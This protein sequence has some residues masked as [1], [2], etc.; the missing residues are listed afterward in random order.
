VWFSGLDGALDPRSDLTPAGIDPPTTADLPRNHKEETGL[1][2][3]PTPRQTKVSLEMKG[4]VVRP[5]AAVRGR[6]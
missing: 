3:L 1:E 5:N 4:L 2:S 6:L